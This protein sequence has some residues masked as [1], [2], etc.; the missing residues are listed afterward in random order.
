LFDVLD[1]GADCPYGATTAARTD[2]TALWQRMAKLF[3]QI[4]KPRQKE[5]CLLCA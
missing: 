5:N 2:T 4:I 3:N 1:A